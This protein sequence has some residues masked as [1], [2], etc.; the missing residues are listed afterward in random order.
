M[1][2]VGGM[3]VNVDLLSNKP[4]HFGFKSLF[5]ADISCYFGLENGHTCAL[6]SQLGYVWVKM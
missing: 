2:R 5:C 3:S 1:Y 4:E 6:H